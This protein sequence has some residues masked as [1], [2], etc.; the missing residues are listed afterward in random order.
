[1][2]LP[3]DLPSQ[4]TD[5]RLASRTNQQAQAF[6]HDGALRPR[7]AATHRLTHQVIVNVYVCPHA[8][9]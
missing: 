8:G 5:A 7:A 6:F 9:T 3:C 1:M 2:T 4:A